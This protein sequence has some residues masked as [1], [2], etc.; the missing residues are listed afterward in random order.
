VKK[1]VAMV[2]TY[3]IAVWSF[4]ASAITIGHSTFP[5]EQYYASTIAPGPGYMG[6]ASANA[7]ELRMSS[8]A[9]IQYQVDEQ[10][11]GKR[12]MEIGLDKLKNVRECRGNGSNCVPRQG[13]STE[14]YTNL[15]TAVLGGCRTVTDLNCILSLDAKTA[16]GKVAEGGI[17][18]DDF[19]GESLQNFIGNKSIDLPD[20]NSSF[21]VDLPGA[22]H[23]AG[24][25]YLVVASLSSKMGEGKAKFDP[26]NLQLG[27]FAV[28]INYGNYPKHTVVPSD[29]PGA[30]PPP[31]ASLNP[32]M[33]MHPY[34]ELCVQHNTGACAIPQ[35]IP[36]DILF[37]IKLKLGVPI[38]G[39]FHGRVTEASLKITE[40]TKD[41]QVYE[42][43][44]KPVIV[45]MVQKWKLHNDLTPALQNFYEKQ[46]QPLRG[47]GEVQRA[48]F[49]SNTDMTWSLLR[50]QTDFSENG[51]QEFLLWLEN[52]GDK[53]VASPSLW[54]I[55]SIDG[56]GNLCY[57]SVN[58]VAGIVQTNATAYVSGP[59]Q[60]N[61]TENS[62]DYKVAGP[63]YLPDGTLNQGTYDLLIKKEVAQCIYGFDK[64]P[65]KA[66]VSIL[67]ADGKETAQTV[68]LSESDEWIKLRAAGFTYSAPL[69]RVK[70]QQEQPAP[71]QQS[72]AP[73]TSTVESAS[74]VPAVKPQPAQKVI[75]CIKGSKTKFV[76]GKNPKCPKGYKI[77]QRETRLINRS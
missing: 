26:A 60:F 24:S 18:F 45:P 73:S 33:K 39:W 57:S 47:T 16:D 58:Q 76:K 77:Y 27:I 70:L 37:T 40:N 32:F 19:R 10:Y 4:S 2:V 61:R 11:R 38:R 28:T 42:I 17:L 43:S 29:L 64:A 21:L 63:H 30:E 34:L 8:S 13:L 35:K 25:K 1:I 14:Q 48:Y 12:P 69:L 49:K 15:Y 75:S 36:S 46:P 51:M 67:S 55:R 6:Y 56:D 68:V 59:P 62:L 53:A 20:G 41:F 65:T 23:A 71:I 52:M 66:T 54:T 5:D 44:A 3:L 31:G 74:S 7:F 50:N 72:A 22:P 9:H